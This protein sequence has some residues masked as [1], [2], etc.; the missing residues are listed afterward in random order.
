MSDCVILTGHLESVEDFGG[1]IGLVGPQGPK[2]DTGQSFAI[3]GYYTTLAA[4]QVAVTTPSVGDAYGVGEAIPYDIYV[5]DT[6]GS[7]WANNGA[8]QGPVGPKG[9]PG[10]EGA[11][12][13]KG[14]PGIEGGH[15]AQKANQ[16]NRAYQE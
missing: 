10:I 9:E 7:A 15:Q 11:P 6:V 14:E 4:L 2:G 12:G 5:W 13:A 16:V 3:L 1:G 8:I